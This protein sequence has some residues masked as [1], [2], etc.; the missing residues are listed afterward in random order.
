LVLL[1]F[2]FQSPFNPNQGH[3]DE[4]DPKEENGKEGKGENLPL[5]LD[6]KGIGLV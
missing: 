6:P 1:E 3:Q 2:H 5:K 4:N